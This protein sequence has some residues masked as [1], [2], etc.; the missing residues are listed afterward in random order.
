MNLGKNKNI[1]TQAGC[2]EM[3]GCRVGS[4]G[5]DMAVAWVSGSGPLTLRQLHRS[6]M[7]GAYVLGH[8]NGIA[9]LVGLQGG[10]ELVSHV[11]GQ[12]WCAGEHC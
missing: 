3:R 2:D 10:I 11:V 1:G 9:A 8:M 12:T 5:T 6:A 7:G 4:L